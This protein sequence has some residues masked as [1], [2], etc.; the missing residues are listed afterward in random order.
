LNRRPQYGHLD[1]VERIVK[2]ILE[3]LGSVLFFSVILHFS[4]EK[5]SLMAQCPYS[6]TYKDWLSGETEPNALYLAW[7]EGYEAHKL[8]LLTTEL[9]LETHISELASEIKKLKDMR[10]ELESRKIKS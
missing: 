1:G 6:E 8:E 10:R 3:F 9:Y 2:P 4:G 7:H 5:G